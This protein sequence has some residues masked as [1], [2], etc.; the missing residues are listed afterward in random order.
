MKDYTLTSV[1]WLRKGVIVV[2]EGEALILNQRKG[3]VTHQ[4][5]EIY[6]KEHSLE[7][8]KKLHELG[9]DLVVV[10]AFNNVGY[11]ADNENMK[12]QR[13]MARYFHEK[14]IKV[15]AYV[16]SIGS[17]FYEGVVNEEKAV[18]EWV[19]VDH[20]GRK[21]T[22]YNSYFRLIPCINK[23]EYLQYVE[24]GIKYA[25]ENLEA[26]LV[27]FDNYGYY[28]FACACN[29]CTKAFREYLNRKYPSRESRLE[30]FGFPK[31]DGIFPP[32]FV[33]ELKWNYTD[34]FLFAG[35]EPG[36]I[37][38]PV[39]QEWIDFRCWRLGEVSKRFKEYIK[40]ISPDIAI[41]WNCPYMGPM[42]GLNNAVFH[43]IWPTSI[44][45]HCDA[46]AAEADQGIL[47]V[48]QDG[49][50]ATRIRTFKSARKLRRGVWMTNF[51]R[52]NI[53]LD[54]AE[55]MAFNPFVFNTVGM[56][57]LDC[58]E[59]ET[60]EYIKFFKHNR[61]YFEETEEIPE[62]ALLN[63][64]PSL[65]YSMT[66]SLI[67]L[68]YFEETL[69]R[70]KIPYSV[71]YDED[72]E[73][74]SEYSVLVL[75]NV[76]Y[77]SSKQI[78]QVENYVKNGGSL[79]ATDQ[80]S[81]LDEWGRRRKGVSLFH[82]PMEEQEYGLENVLGIKWPINEVVKG[83]LGKGK[84]AVIPK[85]VPHEKDLKISHVRHSIGP[86]VPYLKR[87][88][89][90]LP[91][92]WKEI[93]EILNWARKGREI[94]RIEG[95]FTTAAEFLTQRS[96]GR[97]MLHLVNYDYQNIVTGLKVSFKQ[98]KNRIIKKLSF[99]SPEFH[100][101]KEISFETKR[102]KIMFEVPNFKIYGLVVME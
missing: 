1:D 37:N 5:W 81:L 54:L 59:K 99:I 23:E 6:N 48:H 94:L 69:I 70:S 90:Y 39:Q 52:K 41:V 34:P 28:S 93:I 32:V 57:G 76:K 7:T 11:E 89:G 29:D 42:G 67:S 100:A 79:I 4:F 25:V 58:L 82:V 9:I 36:A 97:L 20:Q 53:L 44:Y 24:K 92:N 18:L 60:K 26:D 95:P 80:T 74:I 16:Q 64:Y 21:P 10:Q 63:S 17:V 13:Q 77:M 46:L 3:L 72:L 84:F 19:Q 71:I 47:G 75:P 31:V 61:K 33:D 73:D 40:K 83:T 12:R 62:I 68:I 55:S 56:P 2:Q 8:A 14:G 66:S 91:V 15:G 96:T 38:D 22:Y 88:Q 27:F 35:I 65:S 51:Q 45:P 85:V 98:P 49:K 78:S 43:G 102:G 101:I 30:R 87:L 86:A 50:L